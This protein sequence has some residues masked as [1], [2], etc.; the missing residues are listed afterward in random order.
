MPIYSP[1]IYNV[2][3]NAVV[4]GG[5]GGGGTIS[6]NL[7]EYAS[8]GTWTKPTGLVFIEVVLCGAGGGGGSGSQRASAVVSRAGGGGASGGCIVLAIPASSLGATETVTIGAGGAGGAAVTTIDTD[9]TTGGTGGTTTFGTT[10]IIQMLGGSGGA[11]NLGGT[12]N[13]W[14]SGV[15]PNPALWMIYG[16][17]GASSSSSGGGGDLSENQTPFNGLNI[18]GARATDGGGITTG[19]IAGVGGVGNALYNRSG[20]LSAAAASGTVPGGNGGNGT[21][22]YSDIFTSGPLMQATGNMGTL[23]FGTSAGAGAGNTL[24]VG[25][26]AGLAGKCCSGGSGGGASRNG[27]NSGTGGNGSLG[28]IKILEV[29]LS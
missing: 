8:S 6:Y 11:F 19:N 3:G 14:T 12:P 5:G 7:Q 1:S 17:A 26:S 29:I 28:I 22:N 10:P 4:T 13:F 9:G 16:A 23:H 21:D 24:G 18:G 2:S 25:G 20:I 27:S 15:T